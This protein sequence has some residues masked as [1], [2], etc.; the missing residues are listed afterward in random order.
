MRDD[1][2]IEPHF[3]VSHVYTESDLGGS[4]QDGRNA[5]VIRWVQIARE[6]AEVL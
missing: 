6:E 3:N 2:V 4:G 1:R 5:R